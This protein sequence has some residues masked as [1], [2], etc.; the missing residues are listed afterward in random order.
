MTI[1]HSRSRFGSSKGQTLIEFAVVLP[2]L[3]LVF[4]GVVEFGYLL[5]DQ[6]VVTKLS[7]EGSN[8]TSRNTSLQDAAAAMRGMGTRPVNF[9]ASSRMILS[10]IKMVAT[11][12]TANFNKQVLY[13]RYEYGA[14]AA[15]S[16]LNTAGSPSFGPAPEY[17]A[18]NSDNNTSL[19]VTN[20]PAGLMVPG[21]MLYVTE[22]YTTHPRLTPLDRFGVTVP[23]TLYSIAYF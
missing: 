5:L 20:L 18:T 12:G 4:L 17:T 15:T 22:I 16:K 6:H 1:R 7:R 14:L 8:L 13:A 9:D 2:F 3:M 10:V 11:T 23:T 21:G 19:Q